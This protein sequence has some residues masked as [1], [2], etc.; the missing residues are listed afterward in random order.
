[1][2]SYQQMIYKLGLEEKSIKVANEKI[3][4][5][6]IRAAA[7]SQLLIMAAKLKEQGVK[8]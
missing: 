7:S 2:N 4:S 1:M 6:L 8:G 3:P 5:R